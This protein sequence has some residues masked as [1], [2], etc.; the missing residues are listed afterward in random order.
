MQL[1]KELKPL[2]DS[3]AIP[4]DRHYNFKRLM[5]EP[6]SRVDSNLAYKWPQN[7][8]NH[9]KTYPSPKIGRSCHEN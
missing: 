5:L 9:W 3:V 4:N 8:Q 2:S 7:K 6:Y 1:M